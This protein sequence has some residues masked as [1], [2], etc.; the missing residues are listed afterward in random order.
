VKVEHFTGLQYETLQPYPRSTPKQAKWSNA[1][2]SF[3]LVVRG[4]KKGQER[5]KLSLAPG[6]RI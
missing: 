6:R 5:G 3:S 1:G 2:A 4:N